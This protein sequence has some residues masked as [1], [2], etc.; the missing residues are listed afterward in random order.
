MDRHL[1]AIPAHAARLQVD[2]QSEQFGDG[3][4]RSEKEGDKQLFVIASIGDRGSLPGVPEDTHADVRHDQFS[5]ES[6]GGD[7]NAGLAE[8]VRRPSGDRA[9]H[10]P[11]GFDGVRRGRGGS[12]Q[13]PDAC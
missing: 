7:A 1:V 6:W 5:S 11:S 8:G 9:H 12:D 2:G 13:E 4:H 10:R 3:L